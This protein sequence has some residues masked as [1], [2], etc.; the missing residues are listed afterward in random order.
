VC[1][2]IA[3]YLGNNAEVDQYL[4]RQGELWK[5]GREKADAAAGP[6]VQRLRALA[7]GTEQREP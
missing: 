5:Q 2:A 6:V 1:G 7:A 3:Y 4:C